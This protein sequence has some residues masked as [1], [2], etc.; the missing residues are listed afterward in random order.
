MPR[1]LRTL[2]QLWIQVQNEAIKA[3]LQPFT[4]QGAFGKL[5]DCDVNTIAD[6]NWLSFEMSDLMASKALLPTLT[7]IFHAL[8]PLFDGRPTLLVLDEAWLFLGHGAFAAKIKDWLKTLRRKNVGVVFATQSLADIAASS[9]APSLIESCPTKIYLPSP[10]ALDPETAALYGRFGLNAQQLQLI[11][12]AIP[13]REYYFTCPDGNRLIDLGLGPV[14]LSV[15][16]S[17]GKNDQALMSQLLA[18]HGRAGFA[19][20]FFRA[21]GQAEIAEALGRQRRDAA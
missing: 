9:I 1:P 21:K 14:A 16:G 15:V 17:N 10:G 6:V 11:G 2:T 5:L 20:A 7:Y 4:L 13:K 19:E 8:E 12:T 3:A 18:A